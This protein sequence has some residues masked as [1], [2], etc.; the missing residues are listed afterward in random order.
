MNLKDYM[1]E[2]Y[3]FYSIDLDMSR[4]IENSFRI[5]WQVKISWT[6]T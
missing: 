4:K 1:H 6:K 3:L 2:N 5:E